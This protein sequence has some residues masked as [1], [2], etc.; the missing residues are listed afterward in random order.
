[1]SYESILPAI[2]EVKLGAGSIGVTYLMAGVGTGALIS[3]V[4]L[5]GVR[6][7]S[8]RGKLFLAFGVLSAAAPILLAVSTMREVSII[9]TVL[10][11]ATQAGFMTISHTV[12]QMLTDDSVRGRVAG[13]YSVHVGGSMAI[14]NMI[15]AVL[16][17]VFTAPSVMLVGG[18]LFLGAVVVSFGSGTLRRVYFPAAAVPAAASA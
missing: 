17:D 2:S 6:G 14:T 3:S 13:V 9:A 5:A 11:G 12:I 8:A 10:I 18:L 1:M 15:G 7:A 16:S 4:F